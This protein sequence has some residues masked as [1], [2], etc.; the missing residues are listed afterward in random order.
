MSSPPDTPDA[1]PR[2]AR[3]L[4]GFLALGLFGVLLIAA[5]L[6]IDA[7]LHANDPE[8]AADE[9]LFTLEN[10]GHL[11]LV[12]GIAA[13][14][15]GLYGASSTMIGSSKSGLLRTARLSLLAGLAGFIVI[16]G[17][18]IVGPGL[19]HGHGAGIADAAALSERYTQIPP[20]EAV[21]LVE[22]SLSRIGSLDSGMAHDHGAPTV[23]VALT[24]KDKEELA[25]QLARAKEVAASYDTAEEAAAAGF[26]PSAP[27]A[28]GVGVHWTKWSWV[29]QPFDVER[30]SQLLF[31]EV[32]AGKGP[33]LVAFSYWVSS[34]HEPEGFAGDTDVWHQHVGLCFEDGIVVNEEVPD[35]TQCAG[36]WIN[37]SDLWM[38]HVWIVP[39]MENRLGVFANVNPRFCEWYC[40]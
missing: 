4:R 8:L 9:G 31:E 29:D 22:L 6:A 33:E 11:L 12:V 38:L 34:R 13:T 23:D 21:A 16:M 7:L 25:E 30:P 36:D 17:Y 26:V 1:N 39:G 5:G 28:E 27:R 3:R 35:R 19:G 15:T 18:V 10:P 24:P 32:T 20:D 2:R 37:G 14:A 40:E